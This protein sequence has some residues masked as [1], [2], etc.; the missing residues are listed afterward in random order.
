MGDNERSGSFLDQFRAKKAS[1]DIE[2]A[3]VHDIRRKK[4]YVAAELELDDDRVRRFRIYL[5]DGDVYLPSYAYMS[6]AFLTGDTFLGLILSVGGIE[7]VGSNLTKLLD[8]LQE[9]RIRVLRPFDPEH[10]EPPPAGEPLIEG[11]YRYEKDKGKES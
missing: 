3:T 9:E 8:P 2:G 7:I 5:S 6:N 10:H 1:G 11:I 4:P